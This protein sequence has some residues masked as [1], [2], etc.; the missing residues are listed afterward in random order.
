[1]NILE[2][3]I[4][5]FGGSPV[6]EHN[7]PCSVCHNLHAVYEMNTGIFQPCWPCQKK[8]KLIKR[9]WWMD[10]FGLI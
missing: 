4:N 3:K 9:K 8:F 2:I 7:M 10:F 6:C 5:D 1:M